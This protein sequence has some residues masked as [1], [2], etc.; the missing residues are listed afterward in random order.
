[1]YEYVL[2]KINSRLLIDIQIADRYITDV[3]SRMSMWKKENDEKT[4]STS[5]VKGQ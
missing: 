2:I 4:F 1:M 5:R 3:C